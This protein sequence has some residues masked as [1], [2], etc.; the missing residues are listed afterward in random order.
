MWRRWGWGPY[1]R[2][3]WG[4]TTVAR[5]HIPT[6]GWSMLLLCAIIKTAN[7]ALVTEMDEQGQLFGGKARGND[8]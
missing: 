2:P 4:P 6:A 1:G 3:L 7:L 5:M 8:C